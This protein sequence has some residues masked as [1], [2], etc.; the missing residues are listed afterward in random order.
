MA[1]IP[2]LHRQATKGALEAPPDGMTPIEQLE[3]IKEEVDDIMLNYDR[4]W[5]DE[6]LPE[7]AAKG[8]HI[9]KIEELTDDQKAKMR[10]FFEQNLFPI[11]T[12]LAIDVCHP[13]PFISSLALNLA[14]L[15]CD[16]HG[17][18]KFAR[19]KV[20]TGL[21][22]RFLRIEMDEKDQNKMN[23][24]HFVLIEDLVSSHLDMLFPGMKVL[25]SY[26]FRTT[27]DAEIEIELDETSD[28]LTAVEEGLE[29]RRVGEP[30]RMEV[31]KAMPNN[32]I[33]MMA[34]KFD[35][36]KYL[37]FRS[38]SPLGLMD[39]WQLHRDQTS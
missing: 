21:F 31:D 35:L 7:L 14:V 28:L 38:E 39:L 9:H 30:T 17:H 36:P 18:E 19:V 11:L 23:D 13:F 12:P 8:I 34:S 5:K 32:M 29:S 33:G 6:L 20:P 3:S 16:P 25:A 10:T 4:F 15:V 1:R 27:R 26:G 2:G 24:M 37:V 22:P